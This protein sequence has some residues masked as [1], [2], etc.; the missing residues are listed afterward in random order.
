MKSGHGLPVDGLS[1]QL[2]A[3]F[4]LVSRHVPNLSDEIGDRVLILDERGAPSLELLRFRRTLTSF[5]GFEVALRRRTERLRQFQHS[6][7]GATPAVEYLSEGRGLVLLSS[8]TPERRLSEVLADAQGPVFA[9]SL[10]H[11]LT[12]ALAVLHQYSDG[13]GHGAL[14]ASRI[15]ISPGGQLI[16]V[17]HV[18]APALE[19]LQLTAARMHLE[20][21]IPLPA[22]E[23][24]GRLA[25]GSRTDFFQLGL[26]ALSLL[27]GR[28]LSS[29]EYP[30]NLSD[31]LDRALRTPDREAAE[32]FRGLRGWL[33]RALQ[34]NGRAFPS[35]SDAQDALR[36]VPEQDT[37]HSARRWRELLGVSQPH[38]DD[39]RR[40]V[41]PR[42][43]GRRNRQHVRPRA[44]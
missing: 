15:V 3:D 14:T 44:R 42:S 33:E 22:T 19:R 1:E 37:E 32:Q 20:L 36:D 26:I 5:P 16:V 9:S 4:G 13:I 17:E 27:L 43:P 34:L 38:A 35:S 2:P 23:I 8:Y 24:A 30:R 18:L 25:M 11:Q 7:F 12:P 39:R 40:V 31:V 6:A 10:I 21:G 28:P 29:D 41:G